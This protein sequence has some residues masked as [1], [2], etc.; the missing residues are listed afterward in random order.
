M[1]G[2]VCGE[3]HHRAKHPDD[4]VALARDIAELH[5]WGARRVSRALREAGYVVSFAIVKRWLDYTRRTLLRP[6][7]T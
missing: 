6:L 4:V 7:G 5:G 3:L 1:D 2:N